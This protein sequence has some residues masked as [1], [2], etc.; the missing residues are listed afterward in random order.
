MPVKQNTLHRKTFSCVTLYLYRV[1]DHS[2][3]R[4][5]QAFSHKHL[6]CILFHAPPQS[7]FGHYILHYF[8]VC[9]QDVK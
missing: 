7:F 8:Y 2:L 1:Y 4:V 3:L 6:K 9:L 5:W